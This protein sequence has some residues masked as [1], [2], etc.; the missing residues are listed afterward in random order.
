MSLFFYLQ[1]ETAVIRLFSL[2][3]IRMWVDCSSVQKVWLVLQKYHLKHLMWIINFCSSQ[4]FPSLSHCNRSAVTDN[5]MYSPHITFVYW[6][7]ITCLMPLLVI[8]VPITLTSTKVHICM[9]SW[10]LI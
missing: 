8:R 9:Y 4:Q 6:L 10:W 2:S 1:D 7:N 5:A 3:T